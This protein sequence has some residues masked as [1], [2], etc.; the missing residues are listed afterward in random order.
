MTVIWSSSWKPISSLP[1]EQLEYSA[2]LVI[3]GFQILFGLP[4]TE[5]VV[6]AL[7]YHSIQS[8]GFRFAE[9]LIFRFLNAWRSAKRTFAVN[10]KTTSFVIHVDV[11]FRR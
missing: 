2:A 3:F 1:Y 4:S 6:F 10:T 11:G 5:S 9:S 7:S 8:T